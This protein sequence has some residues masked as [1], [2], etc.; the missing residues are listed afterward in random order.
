MNVVLSCFWRLAAMFKV[1]K[2]RTRKNILLRIARTKTLARLFYHMKLTN[3]YQGQA[4]E[5]L[6][7]MKNRKEIPMESSFRTCQNTCVC[8]RRASIFSRRAVAFKTRC[9]SFDSIDVSCLTFLEQGERHCWKTNDFI[10]TKR[11]GLENQA[12]SQASSELGHLR[13]WQASICS[14]WSCKRKSWVFS[15]SWSTYF[16]Y[17]LLLYC[18]LCNGV[19]D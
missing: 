16:R 11:N 8:I 2:P 15:W 6:F 14:L 10:R 17:G 19:T 9:V 1:A 12:L 13:D 18:E 4:I 3:S 5:K 7:I